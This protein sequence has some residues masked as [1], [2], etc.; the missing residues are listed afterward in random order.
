VTDVFPRIHLDADIELTGDAV[1]SLL[2]PIASGQMLA[3]APERALPRADCSCWVRWYYDVWEALPQVRAGIF[4][5][6]VVAVSAAGQARVDELPSVLSDDLAMSDVFSSH[7]RRVVP[8]AVA[9]VH[10]PR[11]LHDLLRRR[12]RIV[13]GNVQ[14]A[15]LGVRRASSRT[16]VRTLLGLVVK[17][18][19][20]AL[21]LPVFL[22]V[23]VTA[24]LGARRAVRAGDFQTWQRDLSSR[25][26]A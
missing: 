4:G 3:T 26:S 22:A 15:R 2:E 12:I 23:Y 7:E 1:L 18:P 14:A 16:R 11:C 6:G 13:T 21:R 8:E 20:V 5:R 9:I 24:A 10:P 17:S 19:D 25:T